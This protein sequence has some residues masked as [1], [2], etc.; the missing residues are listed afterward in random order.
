MLQLSKDSKINYV[1]VFYKN[2]AGLKKK[3][4]FSSGALSLSK[5]KKLKNSRHAIMSLRAPKHFNIAKHRFFLVNAIF[6][7]RV[8]IFKKIKLNL[9]LPNKLFFKEVLKTQVPQTP[10]I[11][12]KKL[13][14]NF[15]VQFKFN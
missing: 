11:I 5:V 7:V 14:V 2:L 9:A 13:Q 12:I 15:T 10:T 1:L 4:L 3:N 6:L 8:N